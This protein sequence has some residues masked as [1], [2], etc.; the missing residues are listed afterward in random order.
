MSGICEQCDGYMDSIIDLL[1]QLNNVQLFKEDF[2][3]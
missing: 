2:V 1:H 3:H